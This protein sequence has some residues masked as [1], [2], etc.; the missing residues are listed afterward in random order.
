MASD[1]TMMAI[2]HKP[3]Q[4]W[5]NGN[6]VTDNPYDEIVELKVANSALRAENDKLRDELKNIRGLILQKHAQFEAT[7]VPIRWLDS[8]LQ[9]AEGGED[10]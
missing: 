4:H 10:E 2:M 7:P 9:W 8:V 1:M 6:K 5:Q 3:A